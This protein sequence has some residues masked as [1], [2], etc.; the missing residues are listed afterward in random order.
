MPRLSQGNIFQ[1]AS[2]VQLTIVFGRIGFNQMRQ[3]WVEFSAKHMFLSHIKN[4]FNELSDHAVEWSQGKWLWFVAE[5]QNN[6]MTDAQL[7]EVL[8]GIFLWAS[9]Q[10]INSVVTNGISNTDHGHDTASNRASDEQRARF[11][12]NYVEKVEKKYN[13]TIELISLNDVFIRGR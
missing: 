13:F 2:Q 11:L 6:G 10:D 12:E 4:P 1:A 7:T 5:K 9:Q 8:D 3:H